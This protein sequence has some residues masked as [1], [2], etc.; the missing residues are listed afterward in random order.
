M[1]GEI[2]DLGAIGLTQP[3]I[4][5]EYEGDL[6][7]W[8]VV[9]ELA[10]LDLRRGYGGKRYEYR[11]T[12]SHYKKRQDAIKFFFGDD[13]DHWVFSNYC[14]AYFQVLCGIQRDGNMQNVA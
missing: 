1:Q 2:A 10:L 14:G 11:H 3:D 4:A 9:I 6:K 13:K 7:L 12:H 5:K 8:Y